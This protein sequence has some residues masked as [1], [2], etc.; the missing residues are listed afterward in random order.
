MSRLYVV[1]C[2]LCVGCSSWVIGSDEKDRILL[3]VASYSPQEQQ[4]LDT[5]PMTQ[6]ARARSSAADCCQAL[7]GHICC[8]YPYH[9]ICTKLITFVDECCD[10]YDDDDDD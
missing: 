9:C 6:T 4:M 8:G 2:L 10:E 3:S 5:P 7:A 1:I